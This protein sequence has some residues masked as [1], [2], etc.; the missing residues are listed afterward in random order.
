MWISTTVKIINRDDLT[1]LCVCFLVSNDSYLDTKHGDYNLSWHQANELY[2]SCFF[3]P[4]DIRVIYT[5]YN[6]L[7]N[8]AIWVIR[9]WIFNPEVVAGKMIFP[10]IIC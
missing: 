6:I 2:S 9:C 4:Q 8:H 1:S 3:F 7:L 10:K 5:N